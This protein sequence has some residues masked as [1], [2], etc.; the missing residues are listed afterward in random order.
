M[1]K[2]EARNKKCLAVK[3]KQAKKRELLKTEYP[4]RRCSMHAKPVVGSVMINH[5][6]RLVREQTLRACT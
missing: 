5:K 1:G 4:K 6:S 2:H 3:E